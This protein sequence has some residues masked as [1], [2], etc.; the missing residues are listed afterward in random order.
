MKKCDVLKIEW[1]PVLKGA[2]RIMDENGKIVFNNDDLEKCYKWLEK[3]GYESV[4]GEK[5]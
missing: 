2:W 4:K 5:E 3:H 1:N